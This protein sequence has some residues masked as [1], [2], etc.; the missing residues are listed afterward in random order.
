[1]LDLDEQFPKATAPMEKI[2]SGENWEPCMLH[3]LE[4]SLRIPEMCP[5]EKNQEGGKSLDV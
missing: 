5:Q 4:D 1:M 2:E 3:A